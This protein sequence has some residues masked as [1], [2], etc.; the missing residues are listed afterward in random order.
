[1]CEDAAMAATLS[2]AATP[3]ETQAL[4]AV[5]AKRLRVA[6]PNG[7]EPQHNFSWKLIRQLQND[8]RVYRAN[9]ETLRLHVHSFVM[10]SR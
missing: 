10:N 9:R 6:A 2:R 8:L 4:S 7:T 1:M 3:P 5:A